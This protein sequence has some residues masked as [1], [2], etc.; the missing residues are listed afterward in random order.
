[1][2]NSRVRVAFSNKT[3][4]SIIQQRQDDEISIPDHQREYCWNEARKDKF[5]QSILRGFP[6]PAILIGEHRTDKP[7]LEDGNQRIT[8]AIK[9]RNDEFASNG[10]LFSQ[11]SERDQDWFDNYQISIVSYTNATQED[12]IQIFDW[13]Q[14]GAPLSTGE[15]YHAHASTPLIKFVKDTLFTPGSGLHDRAVPIWGARNG[16]DKRRKWLQD[17]VALVTGLAYGALHMTKK[18]EHMISNNFLT[19]TFD[20]D[21]VLRDLQRILEIF[22]GADAVHRIQG[23][24]ARQWDAGNF[25]GYI[26]YSLSHKARTRHETSQPAGERVQYDDGH[27]RPNSLAHDPQEWQRLKTGWIAY[28]CKI[29]RDISRPFKVLL[30]RDLHRDLNNGRN[31]SLSR[32]TKGY[33]NVLEPDAVP[34]FVN[35]GEE[36]SDESDSN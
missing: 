24:N 26:T 23:W 7:T 34:V 2:S 6:C 25:V 29:R 33:M 35:Q 16:A 32:W 3:L 4:Y 19:K 22:E 27:H 14:N 20:S 15:R 1:M 12:R 17:A 28:I 13:H 9:Y 31:W 36:S 8:T 18:Y 11:L 21:G 5:I 30:E 10:K